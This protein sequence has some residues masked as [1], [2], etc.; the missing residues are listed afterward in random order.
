MIWRWFFMWRLIINLSVVNHLSLTLTTIYLTLDNSKNSCTH[1][2]K[3]ACLH[4]LNFLF[5]L[6]LPPWARAYGKW[7]RTRCQRTMWG[8]W[9][10]TRKTERQE[11]LVLR[12][13]EL[14]IPHQAFKSVTHKHRLAHK[15]RDICFGFH[16]TFRCQLIT[17]VK[18]KVKQ[19]DFQVWSLSGLR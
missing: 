18:V 2:H 16:F 4:Q 8:R 5:I 9:F 3:H 17:Q 11:S 12:K 1:M 15:R 6:S 13:R 7:I 14:T 10:T 19:L